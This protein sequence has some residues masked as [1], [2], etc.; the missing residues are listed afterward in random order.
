MFPS[1]ETVLEG[2]RHMVAMQV[3]RDPLVRQCIRQTFTERAK[4]NIV[5][6]KKGKKVQKGGVCNVM[7]EPSAEKVS[8][9]VCVVL[10]PGKSG[11]NLL[12]IH[13]FIYDFSNSLLATLSK[14]G[15]RRQ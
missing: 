3:A 1:T 4:I 6:T 15:R 9:K 5:P 11:L 13:T 8:E 12:V 7:N 2:T 14:L 10:K